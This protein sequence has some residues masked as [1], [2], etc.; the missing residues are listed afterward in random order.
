MRTVRGRPIVAI[1]LA[2]QLVV[3]TAAA[4]PTA[5]LVYARG[6]GA[7]GCPDEDAI[8][9]LVAARL[10]YSPF[11]PIA[12]NTLSAEVRRAPI[13]F[14]ADVK[15][16]DSRGIL[17]GARH[18]TTASDDCSDLASAMAL[19]MS[20]ALDPLS[21]TR[22]PP[23][24]SP[25]LGPL[26][27]SPS[28]EG[29]LPPPS[30]LPPRSDAPPSVQPPEAAAS[31]ATLHVGLG[32]VVSFGASPAPAVGVSA[33]VGGRWRAW[34][35]DLGG[36]GD[37]PASRPTDQG[38]AARTSL[39]AAFVAPC[40]H[41]GPGFG[42]AVGWLGSLSAS[43]VS[44]TAPRSTSGVFAAAGPRLGAGVRASKALSFRMS[45]DALFVL[46]PFDLKLNGQPV[47]SAASVAFTLTVAALLHSS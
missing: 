35:L 4:T 36:R 8:A 26:P 37:L 38:G 24:A 19:S 29:L 7:E 43:A 12:D 44:V 16:V 5:R 47:F 21:L 28:E 13:G 42:C 32:P 15:L 20:I 41:V 40:A 31:P 10:G 18:L 14:S 3:A 9:A 11:R 30:S 34:S 25:D 22:P 2:G 6:A 46:T 17:R 33:F 1:A 23:S 39:V 45:G 27:L